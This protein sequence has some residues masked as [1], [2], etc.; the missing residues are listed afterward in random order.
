VGYELWREA[1]LTI[2]RVHLEVKKT[3][4]RHSLIVAAAVAFSMLSVEANAAPIVQSQ[5]QILTVNGQDMNFLFNALPA[6]DGSGGTITIASGA[7]TLGGIAGLDLSGAFPLE[8]ENFE[9]TF[10]GGAQ[11]SFSCGGPSNNGSTAISGA[12]DNSFNF[13]NCVFSL[14]FLLSGA[15]LASLLGDSSLTIGVLFGD[16][17]STFGDGDEVIV[18]VSY[19]S[20]PEPGTFALLGLGL[21]LA[22]FGASRR[23]KQ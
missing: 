7:S 14:Q 2:M 9:V 17:V 15:N 19:N 5:T 16:D 11:G 18:T 3:I 20:V 21:G 1:C 10:D 23:R 4:M 12:A 6:G 22:G 8:D 13:N